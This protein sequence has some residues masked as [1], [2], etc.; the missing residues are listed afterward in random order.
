[1]TDNVGI[2]RDKEG[3]TKGLEVIATLRKEAETAKAHGSSQY[4]P[5][6]SECIDLNCLLTVS[7]AVARSARLREESR[8]AH[9]RV[10]FQG[11][12]EEWGNYNIVVRRGADGTMEIERIQRSEAP[13]HLTKIGFATLEDLEA[14][15]V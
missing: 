10:D 2:W 12:R 3:L 7:E 11:E 15:R 14:G 13:E 5:G 6:W 4:N 1:M 9:S 8:G